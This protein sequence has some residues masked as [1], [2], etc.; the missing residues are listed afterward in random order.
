MSN[1]ADNSQLGYPVSEALKGIYEYI[2]QT[3][4]KEPDITPDCIYTKLVK[5]GFININD[6]TFPINFSEAYFLDNHFFKKGGGYWLNA[7][8]AD[9][10]SRPVENEL[11]ESDQKIY[12][13]K[14]CGIFTF[15][16]KFLGYADYDQA[17]YHQ[18]TDE[19]GEPYE[20][21]DSDNKEELDEQE[22]SDEQEELDEQ[23][24]SDE[25]IELILSESKELADELV[26]FIDSRLIGE[27]DIKP[28]EMYEIIKTHYPDLGITRKLCFSD[29]NKIDNNIFG[30]GGHFWR[31]AYG[32]PKE[33]DPVEI[34]GQE[35]ETCN[36]GIFTFD[37]Y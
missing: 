11:F 28:W 2:T 24:E 17:Y 10:S 31:T 9:N 36:V 7:Y 3:I 32:L 8:S 14:N 23:E 18:E 16:Y 13:A 5:D 35:C 20:Q 1:F 12:K 26:K 6:D 19:Q 37:A 4:E 30:K 25:D 21:E 34:F 33:S 15:N 29:A 22:E 27:P